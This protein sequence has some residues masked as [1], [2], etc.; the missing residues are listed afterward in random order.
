MARLARVLAVFARALTVEMHSVSTGVA[1][2]IFTSR[3]SRHVTPA[4][5]LTVRLHSVSTGFFVRAR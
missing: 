5:A 4:F 2:G 3:L 1:R